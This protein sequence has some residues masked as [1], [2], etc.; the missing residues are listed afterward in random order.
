MTEP[1]IKGA[2][3]VG[4]LAKEL[5]EM[6]DRM[7]KNA[8]GQFGG[9]FVVIDPNGNVVKTLI[10]DNKQ[11]PAQFWS[12]LKTKCDMALLGLDEMQRN[13]QGYRR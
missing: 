1:L 11:D 4:E 5:R 9:A 8:D 10:I 12:I 2:S 13:Q 3:N 7:E 6:A